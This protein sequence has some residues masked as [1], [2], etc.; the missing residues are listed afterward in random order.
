MLQASCDHT[1]SKCG[2]ILPAVLPLFAAKV[3]R[4]N[5]V[6]GW[7]RPLLVLRTERAGPKIYGLT[8]KEKM[9]K[10]QQGRCFILQTAP[11]KMFF[12]KYRR[13]PT[14][15]GADRL[16][17]ILGA[18]LDSLAAAPTEVTKGACAGSHTLSL[19][20]W[21]QKEPESNFF[22]PWSACC[23]FQ[24]TLAFY[25]QEPA[26]HPACTASFNCTSQH[27]QG[28]EKVNPSGFKLSG[29]VKLDFSTHLP[30]KIS[31]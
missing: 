16:C 26:L 6:L 12:W 9:V 7:W 1:G 24:K 2:Q 22:V 31:Q 23:L 17:S 25:L 21:E 29:C 19:L 10:Q 27:K 20:I 30:L 28:V 14:P 11:G 5:S 4:V 13:L 3:S 8:W 18:P 15:W